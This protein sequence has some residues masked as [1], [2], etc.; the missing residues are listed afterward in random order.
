MNA[1]CKKYQNFGGNIFILSISWVYTFFRQTFGLT[2]GTSVRGTVGLILVKKDFDCFKFYSI[3]RQIQILFFNFFALQDILI[4]INTDILTDISV[5]V[6][7][8][9]EKHK[10]QHYI[11]S[12]PESNL[13]HVLFSV[14]PCCYSHP[15][16]CEN[17]NSHINV[18]AAI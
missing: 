17:I 14:C 7:D 2:S 10:M 18:L 5:G 13:G 8:M 4:Y 16:F 15:M 3:D 11:Y 1:W 9:R 12:E 6:I